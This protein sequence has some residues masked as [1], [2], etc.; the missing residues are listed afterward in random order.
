MKKF[1]LLAA[2]VCMLSAVASNV[3]LAGEEVCIGDRN[4]PECCPE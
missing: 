4:A 3:A 1:F 2:A